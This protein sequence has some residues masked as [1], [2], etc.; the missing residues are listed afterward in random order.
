MTKLGA[1]LAILL[2]AA[3]PAAAQEPVVAVSDP[4]ALFV[5][6]DPALHAN[7]QLALHFM[8]EFFQC[9]H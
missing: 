2:C 3:F 8:R 4:E 1:V 7:K 6:A 9:N 5:D